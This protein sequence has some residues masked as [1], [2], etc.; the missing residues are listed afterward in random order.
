MRFELDI[1]KVELH[2]PEQTILNWQVKKFKV[3]RQE[4]AYHNERLAPE[5]PGRKL[6]A[7]NYLGLFYKES[8]HEQEVCMMSNTSAEIKDLMPFVDQAEGNVLV[9]GLG[10]G[11]TV[12]MLLDRP[13][14][15]TITVIEKDTTII[16]LVGTYYRQIAP[17]RIKIICDDAY[18][19]ETKETY[20]AIFIDI[21]YK[22]SSDNLYQMEELTMKYSEHSN[23][24]MCWAEKETFRL[25]RLGL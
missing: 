2:V 3:S 13:Q 8:D 23:V 12:Q 5:S 11:L 18:D 24:V 22:L 14:V 15:K 16:E 1:P 6:R 10:L 19:H 17:N 20:D 25:S 21:W 7:G 4:A 9:V